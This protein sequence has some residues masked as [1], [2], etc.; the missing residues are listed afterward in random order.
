M[1]D[2]KYRTDV[3]AHRSS[4]SQNHCALGVREKIKKNIQLHRNE[5]KFILGKTVKARRDLRLCSKLTQFK[6]KETEVQK[7]TY[8]NQLLLHNK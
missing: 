6:D 2:I 7:D 4:T 5:Q 3:S 8:I 1:S